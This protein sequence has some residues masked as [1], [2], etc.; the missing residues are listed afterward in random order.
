MGENR[1]SGAQ[2]AHMS[3]WEDPSVVARFAARVPDH[4]LSELL[5]NAR[6]GLLVLD[7]GCAGGRNTVHAARRGADVW[8]LDASLPMV[9]ET[10]RRLSG[11][12]GATEAERRVRHGLMSDLSGYPRAAFD[13][14][15]ALGVLQDARNVR[16]FRAAVAGISEILRP[17]GLCLVA[18]F[19]PDSQPAGVPLE[20]LAGEEHVWLGFGAPERRMTLLGAADL[21]ALFLEYGLKTS[22]RTRAVRVP[23]EN[24]FRITLNALYV[25]A[26][27]PTLPAG[28]E[29]R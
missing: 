21:D 29:G 4:R 28:A 16:E 24:G 25:K 9:M 20:R 6:P 17:G 8:A 13:L 27:E 22:E 18:N 11:V 7:V 23:T 1:N 19:G 15:I 26:G 10:R 14:V 2:D 3:R 5:A 12:I